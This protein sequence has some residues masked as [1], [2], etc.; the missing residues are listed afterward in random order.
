MA[1]D[2]DVFDNKNPQSGEDFCIGRDDNDGFLS[3]YF[4]AFQRLVG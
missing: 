3:D 2:V 4:S 1:I